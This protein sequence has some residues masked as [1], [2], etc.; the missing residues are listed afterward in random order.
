MKSEVIEFAKL[1]WPESVDAVKKMP[2]CIIPL[3]AIEPHGLHL[4]LDTDCRIGLEKCRRVCAATGMILMPQIPIG[5][6]YSLYSHA[7]AMTFKP[8][9]LISVLNDIIMSCHDRGFRIIFIHSHHGGNGPYIREAMRQS[10]AKFPE[11]KIVNLHGIEAMKKVVKDVCGS[12]VPAALQWHSDE[13][14]T[15]QALACFTEDIHMD[16]AICE[17]PEQPKDMEY[18][19]YDWSEY[20]GNCVMG[21]ATKGTKEKGEIFIKTETDYMIEMAEYVMERFL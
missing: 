14:E 9:T 17:Y 6:V 11:L 7:G 8:E 5:Q 2:V 3:G 15:S 21:D 19:V 13:I 4:P 10:H 12:P 18:S 20:F 16:R 1:T